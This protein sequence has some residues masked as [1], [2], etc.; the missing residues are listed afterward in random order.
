MF[1]TVQFIHSVQ[2]ML[3]CYSSKKL[4]DHFLGHSLD[5]VDLITANFAIS[6]KNIK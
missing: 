6:I 4:K 2:Y 5:L 1:E 3:Q